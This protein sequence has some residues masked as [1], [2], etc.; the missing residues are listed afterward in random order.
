MAARQPNYDA[1]QLERARMVAKKRDAMPVIGKYKTQPTSL[2][3]F[4][5]DQIIEHASSLGG[6]FGQ[7]KF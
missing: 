7:V 3:S 4:S 2:S 1:T 5:D 6:V